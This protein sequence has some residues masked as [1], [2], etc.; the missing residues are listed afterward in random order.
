M[1]GDET[2]FAFFFISS[3]YISLP[4]QSCFSHCFSICGVLV[5]VV[6]VKQNRST[7][8]ASAAMASDVAIWAKG[9]NR[10]GSSTHDAHPSSSL[11]T[12][13]RACCP[14]LAATAVR[15]GVRRTFDVDLAC[16][17]QLWRVSFHQSISPTFFP[18]KHPPPWRADAERACIIPLLLG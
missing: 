17:C 12:R 14:S 5:W 8:L 4:E 13:T 16:P 6:S 2:V 1:G 15:A 3:S 11:H 10:F 7:R 18:R 9:H